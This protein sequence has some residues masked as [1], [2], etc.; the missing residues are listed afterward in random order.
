MAQATTFR[1]SEFLILV[2]DGAS[3]EEFSAPC[4]L[5]SRGFNRTA[6]TN[7][8]NVP[9]CADEDLP[10]WQQNDVV[11]LNWSLSGE[12]VMADEAKDVW[13]AWFNSGAARNVRI[14]LGPDET[15][16]VWEGRAILS[17][18]NI[19]GERGSRVTV[20]VEMTGDGQ[21]ALMASA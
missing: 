17:T 2:G 9:D 1:F 13:E 8:T 4:G 5:T 6:E 21:V 18:F 11:A 14:S 3:P 10:T 19:S 7:S 15:A 12:G 16:D 20:S